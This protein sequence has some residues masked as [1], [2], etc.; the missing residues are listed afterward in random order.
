MIA[1][2]AEHTAL[3]TALCQ[4]G[5]SEGDNAQLV[6]THISSILLIGDYAY[7]IK[8]P[9]DFGFLDF[10]TLAHRKHF[11]E[12]E[13]RLNRRLAPDLYLDVVP[14]GGTPA[15]PL[16]GQQ[17]AIEY[18][19]KMHRFDP[20]QTLDQLALQRSLL[21]VHIDAIAQ[22]L[23]AF[24]H[25]AR[26]ADPKQGYGTP[27]AVLQPMHDN[28]QQLAIDAAEFTQEAALLDDLQ[29]WTVQ[30]GQGLASILQQRL[31][32]GWVRECHG[33]LH[34]GNI[35]L[36]A[37]AVTL[38]DGI[39]FNPQLIWVD[40]ISD[41]AFLFM[42]LL[43]RD[44]RAMAYRFLN[45]YLADTGDYVGMQ[46]LPLYLVYRAL[47]RA[48]VAWLT[49]QQSDDIDAAA[50]ALRE[51]RDYLQFAH[52]FIQPKSSGMVLMHGPS[53]CG[54][55]Y[56]ASRVAECV[57]IL[58]LRADV[59]RKRLYGLAMDDRSGADK[60]LYSP[61]A[62]QRTYAHLRSLT[63]LLLKNHQKVLV[64]ATFLHAGSRSEFLA[65]AEQLGANALILACEAPPAV[66]Q[67]RV[68]RR[69]AL[70]D[71]HSDADEQVLQSQL[72]AYQPLPATSADVIKVD[73][74]EPDMRALCAAL[75]HWPK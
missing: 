28:F 54:K 74:A 47:V 20:A 46:V 17:P 45:A 8:K 16:P 35:A 13:L 10:S 43:K 36:V 41:V 50:G 67:Q 12:E 40:V 51:M 39:E 34:L 53:G 59:E 64:D 70:N 32:E 31:Q 6:Q 11:C 22:Q 42:D 73:G 58:H 44:Q 30:Q 38:F 18:A 1:S 56:I 49:S 55:S 65:L 19:V 15:A 26:Q 24:H 60:G 63:E 75:S 27:E 4:G 29:Q 23:A 71:D 5:L 2:L 14:I 9:V 68:G 52:A 61:Q 21:P 3:V 57:G 69:R 72:Q 37:D 48:K 7:K 25:A 66:M 33:D 62:H